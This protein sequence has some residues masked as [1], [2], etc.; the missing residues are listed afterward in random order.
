MQV[1]VDTSERGGRLLDNDAP[2]PGLSAGV[3]DD[4]AREADA[5]VADVIRVNLN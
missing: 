3:H 4:V 2:L 5:A 1:T